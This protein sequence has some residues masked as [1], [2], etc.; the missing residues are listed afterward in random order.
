MRTGLKKLELPE[1][2]VCPK[3]GNILSCML[4]DCQARDIYNYKTMK[5][6][7]EKWIEKR[8]C[9]SCA[10]CIDISDD[11]DTCHLCELI[12]GDSEDS[13]GLIPIKQSCEHFKAIP[14]EETDVY[15]FYTKKKEIKT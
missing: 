14:W 11:R 15:K 13:H 10:H 5:N 6:W 7:H 1:C 9:F 2:E 12:A 4:S 8:C 3:S